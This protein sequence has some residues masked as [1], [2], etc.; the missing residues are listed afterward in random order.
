MNIASL[1]QKA[2]RTPVDQTLD[3]LVHRAG[4]AGP[5]D[6]RG[7]LR[8]GG[9]T[10]GLAAVVA[11]CGKTE[12]GELGRVGVAPSVTKLPEAPIGDGVLLRTMAS[13]QR[14]MIAVYDK[15]IADPALL[16]P[17]MRPLMQQLRDDADAAA[18][19]FDELTVTAGG[20]PWTCSNPKFDSASIE[21]ALTRI[22]TGIPATAEAKAIA[23]SDDMRR[24][25]LNLVHGMESIIGASEQRFV[26][27]IGQPFRV[28]T[29]QAAVSNARHSALLALRIN[30]TRPDGYVAA[31]VLIDDAETAT[32][33]PSSTTTAPGSQTNQQ[34]Q[35]A[36]ST[37]STAA[38]AAG[39]GTLTPIPPVSA[40]NG[41][42]GST[43]A[44]EV[45]VGA[46]D[47]NGTRL[48]IQLQT[49][50]LN[51]FVYDYEKPAC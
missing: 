29:V 16:D 33:T 31:G 42:Y 9:L 18:K 37:A 26:E 2:A 12:A 39:G 24:D 27:M 23:K 48:K 45:V 1:R 8:I 19:K 14:S 50:S 25:V 47:E 13:L 38:P 28:A 5:T 4:G 51:S 6:R 32:P 43:A 22:T 35:N 49:V 36:G 21:P 3:Q 10:V 44:E 20:T 7:F 34:G 15:A 11:A 46:G 30:P 41:S 40:I 17:A